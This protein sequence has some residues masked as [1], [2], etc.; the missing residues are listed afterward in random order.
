M[1][2]GTLYYYNV[3]VF[4]NCVVTFDMISSGYVNIVN[5]LLAL[6]CDRV[7]E[8]LPFA[9]TENHLM[10]NPTSKSYQLYREIDSITMEIP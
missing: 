5:N 3:V 6:R 1:L 8:H 4:K 2:N 7:A 10:E 9:S